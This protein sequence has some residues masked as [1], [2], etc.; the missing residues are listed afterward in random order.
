MPIVS[1]SDG[2]SFEILSQPV[3]SQYC[4]AACVAMVKQ[5]WYGQCLVDNDY[6]TIASKYYRLQTYVPASG[7]WAMT[8]DGIEHVLT[9]E[10]LPHYAAIYEGPYAT[11]QRMRYQMAGDK[12]AWSV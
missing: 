3:N 9:E 10:K 2:R 8:L 7:V 6:Y 4:W 11:L 5:Q 12:P 1:D